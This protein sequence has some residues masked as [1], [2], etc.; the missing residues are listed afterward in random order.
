LE[1]CGPRGA[2]RFGNGASNNRLV[3]F[4]SACTCSPEI[5][6]CHWC[7]SQDPVGRKDTEGKTADLCPPRL[8]YALALSSLF[9]HVDTRSGQF[10]G[11][12]S[13][14][15]ATQSAHRFWPHPPGLSSPSNT[16]CQCMLGDWQCFSAANLLPWVA[17]CITPS[18]RLIQPP[19]NR[20]PAA[21]TATQN[22]SLEALLHRRPMVQVR[23]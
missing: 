12:I 6:H 10:L 7:C 23:V 16:L 1:F 14:C 8:L 4:R 11:G 3:C 2:R 22:A 5:T 20:S 17:N 13:G 15:C 9:L 21:D 19:L 18:S